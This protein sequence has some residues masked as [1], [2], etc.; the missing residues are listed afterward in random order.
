MNLLISHLF[1]SLH[2]DVAQGLPGVVFFFW[3]GMFELGG[4]VKSVVKDIKERKIIK[5]A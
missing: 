2:D 3:C 4:G 1:S 5:E